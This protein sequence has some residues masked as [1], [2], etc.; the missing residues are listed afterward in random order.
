VINL[1]DDPFGIWPILVNPSRVY[2]H[3]LIGPNH[4]GAFRPA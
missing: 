2:D 3:A 1:P 4:G